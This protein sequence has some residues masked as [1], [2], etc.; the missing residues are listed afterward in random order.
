[1]A[2]DV[3]KS[4]AIRSDTVTV[5]RLVDPGIMPDDD[6][7]REQESASLRPTSFNEYPGQELA[8]RSLE[9]YVKAAILRDS[10]LDHVVLHGPPGLGKTT[11]ANIIAKELGRPFVATSGPALDRPG[12]LAGI[13]SSLSHGTVL[14]IDEVH[15]LPIKV[16][17]ILYTAMEDF[18]IDIV[19]GQGPSARTVPVELQPFTLIG[20]TTRLSLISAPLISRFG[21][22]E[23]LEY[24]SE[25]ALCQIL[26]RSARVIGLNLSNSGNR[27][28]AMRSRG[29]PRIA[30]RLLKRV[31]DFAIVA[32]IKEI[33]SD[34]AHIAL[35]SQGI[36]T[37]GLDR[38]D[39]SILAV[40]K[41]QYDGGPVGIDSISASM[42]EDRSTI[43]DVYE[44]YLVH[45][46]FVARTSRGRMLT[47]MAIDLLNR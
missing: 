14:F 28:I 32:G 10:P 21:I 16:E 17:E 37:S 27:E 12:D 25:E 6:F 47:K 24:Y 19:V 9:I 30:N 2:I 18:R 22:Q 33:E 29:T 43:E 35:S 34:I 7:E 20:A 36:D 44:P 8:K 4:K 31:A 13:L 11:L 45:R 26:E 23:R 3:E 42:N 1:M 41:E 5:E 39:R 46:G 40:M 15:R 38:I